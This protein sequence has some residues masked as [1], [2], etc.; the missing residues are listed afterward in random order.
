[1]GFIKTIENQLLKVLAAFYGWAISIR[2]LGFHRGWLKSYTIPELFVVSIG[3][4]VLGGT[5]KTPLMEKLARTLDPSLI[6]IVGRGY[7]SRAEKRQEPTIVSQGKGP[8][9]S[10]DEGGDEAWWLA[11]RLPGVTVISSPCR[12]KGATWAKEAG[13]EVV[14]LEDGMQHR[15]LKRD[16]EIVVVDGKDPL[17]GEAYVPAGRLRDSLQA[18]KRA[19]YVVVNHVSSREEFEKVEKALRPYTQAPLIGVK[20]T[21]TSFV[22]VS[23]QVISLPKGT[24]VGMLAGIAKPAHFRQLLEEKGLVI[25]EEWT[26][27]DHMTVKE[28][29]LKTWKKKCEEKGATYLVCTEKDQVKLHSS[30]V[31]AAKMELEIRQGLFLWDQLIDQIKRKCP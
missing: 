4:V 18:M 2:H 22:D 1:M 7:K 16:I 24:K 9:C 6:A 28:D 29:E 11:S 20:P 10:P 5:G 31:L 26:P 25:V 17:G 27:G 3:N 12:V 8:C 21:L 19:D 23:G 14:L 15:R 30:L 13:K